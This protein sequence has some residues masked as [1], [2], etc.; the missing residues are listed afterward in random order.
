MNEVRAIEISSAFHGSMLRFG[1]L[2]LSR[3][4]LTLPLYALLPRRT[5]IAWGRDGM[6]RNAPMAQRIGRPTCR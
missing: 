2:C 3:S 4:L 6:L 5:A 1:P